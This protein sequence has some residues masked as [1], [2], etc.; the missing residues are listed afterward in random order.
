MELSTINVDNSIAG[1]I[2]NSSVAVST[3]FLTSLHPS[4]HLPEKDLPFFRSFLPQK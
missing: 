3:G 1:K 4:H 2:E